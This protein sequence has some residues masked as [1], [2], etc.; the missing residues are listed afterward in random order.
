MITD[1][2]NEG[3]TPLDSAVFRSH[4]M[5][6]GLPPDGNGNVGGS[7]D[8]GFVSQVPWNS[9]PTSGGD[10]TLASDSLLIDAGLDAS[11]SSTLDLLGQG[12]FFD[13]D[14]DSTPT[15]DI[16]AYERR[17]PA[18][19]PMLQ[20]VGVALNSG[21]GAVILTVESNFAGPFTAQWNYDLSGA[22]TDSTTGTVLIRDEH[23][24]HTG[25][26]L[27]LAG[28]RN[29]LQGGLALRSVRL[30][31]RRLQAEETMLHVRDWRWKIPGQNL[32]VTIVG[33]RAR[34]PGA[35]WGET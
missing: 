21:T 9:A 3:I 6:D 7:L 10:Y 4:S 15:I 11:T 25:N 17:I 28:G 34:E 30:F 20:I 1:N 13:G 32:K 22:W 29:F 12:R 23:D 8:P 19:D 31:P 35:K 14:G 18:I 2:Q 33:R 16:G 26:C 27:R 24:H 5:I